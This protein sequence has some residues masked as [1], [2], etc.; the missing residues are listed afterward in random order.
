MP[1]PQSG[2]GE[3]VDGELHLAWTTSRIIRPPIPI[4][5]RPVARAVSVPQQGREESEAAFD[6]L[7]AK[8]TPAQ[9]KLYDSKI[10]RETISRDTVVLRPAAPPR[11]VASLQTRESRF[12]RP[13]VR[14][15]P[16]A[17]KKAKDQERMDAL[18]A[19]FGNSIPGFKQ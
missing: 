9:R 4:G 19:V 12:G 8:M 14:D 17:G 16:D 1:V 3:L 11:Q 6:Q 18:H 2:E 7:L 10:S 15:V 13:R 5:P